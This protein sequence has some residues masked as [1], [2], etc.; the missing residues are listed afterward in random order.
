MHV[1]LCLT[2]SDPM[3]YSLP[4]SS[5]CGI[6]Q[7]RCCSGLSL[8]DPGIVS[9]SPVSPALQGDSSLAEPLGKSSCCILFIRKTLQIQLKYT[10]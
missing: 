5:V 4:S 2:L 9:A 1:Q 8:P 10:L 7:A 3:D 6:F